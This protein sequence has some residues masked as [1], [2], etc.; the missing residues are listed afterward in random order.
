[1]LGYFHGDTMGLEGASWLRSDQLG[2]VGR[3]RVSKG[4]EFNKA[5]PAPPAPAAPA[6][7][8]AAGEN[9][10]SPADEPP[11]VRVPKL[12]PGDDGGG[13]LRCAAPGDF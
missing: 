11:P 3:R 2:T 10:A 12:A 9:G 6:S 8:A 1:M 5:V 13:A 7:L 4:D